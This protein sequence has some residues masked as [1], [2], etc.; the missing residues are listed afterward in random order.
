MIQFKNLVA[1]VVLS[2]ITLGSV[3]LAGESVNPDYFKAKA[4]YE[5]AIR[6]PESTVSNLC[7]HEWSLNSIIDSVS[8]YAFNEEHPNR[9][10]YFCGSSR[11]AVTGEVVIN[12]LDSLSITLM[13]SQSAPYNTSFCTIYER[14]LGRYGCDDY[15]AKLSADRRVWTK[16]VGAPIRP[17]TRRELGLTKQEAN[18][19]K[20]TMSCT[21]TQA[22]LSVICRESYD[23]KLGRQ[24]RFITFFKN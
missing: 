3:A 20:K 2:S 4:L 17:K 12:R 16:S 21:V 13:E 1:V 23:K 22:P 10:V 24:D 5:E 14:M 8:S 19:L 18:Q 11:N 9:G 6:K 15:A 7:A